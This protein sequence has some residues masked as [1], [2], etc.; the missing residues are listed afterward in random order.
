MGLRLQQKGASSSLDKGPLL[1]AKCHGGYVYLEKA[2]FLKSNNDR[3]ISPKQQPCSCFH[4]CLHQH[5]S[6][7]SN[8]SSENL[9]Q[10]HPSFVQNPPMALTALTVK[11]KAPIVAHKVL[12]D[13]LPNTSIILALT[14]LFINHSI[15]TAL[16]IFLFLFFNIYLFGCAWSLVVAFELLVVA[17]E[18]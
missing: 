16:D 7:Q 2:P 4:P 1:Q 5:I 13:L 15:L 8:G 12:R 10:W 3:Q 18:V 14:S 6:Q 17:C 9:S 11:T